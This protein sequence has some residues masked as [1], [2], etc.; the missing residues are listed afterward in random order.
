MYVASQVAKRSRPR[1]LLADEVGLGKTIEAGLIIHHLI[2]SGRAERVLILVPD[3][4]VYQWFVEMLKKFQLSFQAINHDTGLARGENPFE[5]GQLFVASE[6]YLMKESHLMEMAMDSK[7]DLLVVDEA[8]LLRWSPDDSSPEYDF[9]AALAKD[10]PGVLLLSGTPEILGLAG[11]YARLHLLDPNRFHSFESFITETM[12]YRP[13]SQ[14]AC[15]LISGRK[16][17]TEEY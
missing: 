12:C 5:Q 14:L 10:T 2:L 9:V 13:I 6:K 1:V 16:L 3:S 7:W 11:H 4:L 17:T 15:K 8:H